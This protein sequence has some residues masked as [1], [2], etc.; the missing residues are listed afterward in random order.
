MESGSTVA[1]IPCAGA[2]VAPSSARPTIPADHFS[3]NENPFAR[4][5]TPR[6]L[7]RRVRSAVLRLVAANG[8]RHPPLGPGPDRFTGAVRVRPEKQ[9]VL[10][11]G[12][13]AERQ[14]GRVAGAAVPRRAYRGQGQ[15]R[16]AAGRRPAEADITVAG[17]AEGAGPVLMARLVRELCRTGSQHRVLVLHVPERV[18]DHR[19]D[20]D[21]GVQVR[22]RDH[23]AHGRHPTAPPGRSD[24]RAAHVRCA[25]GQAGGRARRRGSVGQRA[26]HVRRARVPG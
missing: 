13:P 7:I 25:R 3:D 15:E 11:T 17:A 23:R 21:H 26:L 12:V 8:R 1:H 19:N 24:E 16:A 20:T 6:W 14:A 4:H 18:A 5:A 9:R 22:G 10:G 2:V